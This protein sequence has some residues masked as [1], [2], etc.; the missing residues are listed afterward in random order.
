MSFD[1]LAFINANGTYVVVV[2][3]DTPGSFSIENLP[4]G[5]YG[6]C[7]RPMRDTTSPCRM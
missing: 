7:T 6:I 5:T 3:A 1:P 4:P 2:K